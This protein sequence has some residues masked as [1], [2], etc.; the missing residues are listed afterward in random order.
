MI[1]VLDWRLRVPYKSYA[2]LSIFNPSYNKMVSEKF[3]FKQAPSAAAM[4]LEQMIQEMDNVDMTK[5]VIH[6]RID[7]SLNQYVDNQDIVEM[8]TQ[9]PDRFMGFCG[10]DLTEPAQAIQSIEELV[11]KGPFHGVVLEPGWTNKPYYADDEALMPLY[12]Y[13]NEH[14]LIA[15]LQLGHGGGPDLSYNDPVIVDRLAARFPKMKIVISHGQ[16]P[17][18]TAAVQ[19][20]YR[21]KNIWICPDMYATHTP[22]TRE[23]VEGANY[24]AYDRMI[25]GTAYP[26]L[27]IEDVVN[28]VKQEAGL[29]ARAMEYYLYKNAADL[30]GIE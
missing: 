16:Y 10:V 3:G 22:G 29:N 11:V 12:D 6:G 4:S 30:L 27:P 14:E 20:A 13:M 15:A 1:K 5:A 7:P 19:M 23:Y 24:I 18:A 21:R 25:F 8:M 17:Y 9:Y 2:N 26:L 28:F